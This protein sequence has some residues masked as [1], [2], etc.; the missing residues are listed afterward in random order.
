M[1]RAAGF[2]MIAIAMLDLCLVV[3]ND[4][5]RRAGGHDLRPLS[6]LAIILLIGGLGLASQRLWFKRTCTILLSIAGVWVAVHA[7][8]VLPL[9]EAGFSVF[10]GILLI[11]PLM[12]TLKTWLKQPS[13]KP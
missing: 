9:R 4:R 12:L 5:A 7:L 2:G 6:F 11:I 8:A 10:L 13:S 3:L 1:S